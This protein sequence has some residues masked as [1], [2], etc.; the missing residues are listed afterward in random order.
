MLGLGRKMCSNILVNLYIL[1][2]LFHTDANGTVIFGDGWVI[3]EK[4]HSPHFYTNIF[5]E[6]KSFIVFVFT[7]P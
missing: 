3:M 7:E 1:L 4:Q 5:H 2:H 6:M